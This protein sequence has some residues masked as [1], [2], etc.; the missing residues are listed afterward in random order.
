M[1]TN[2]SVAMNGTVSTSSSIIIILNRIQSQY[3]IQLSLIFTILG[4]FGFIQPALRSNTFCL[5]TLFGSV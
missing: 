5:Y 3:L 2:S 1:S 4:L